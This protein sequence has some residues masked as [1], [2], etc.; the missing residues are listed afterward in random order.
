MA[1]EALP[2]LAAAQGG[3]TLAVEMHDL[4][5]SAAL[6]ARLAQRLGVTLDDRRDTALQIAA[7]MDRAQ[8]TAPRLLLL[9][10]A[11]HLGDL[12]DWLARLQASASTLKL[13][14]TSRVRLQVP[15]EQRADAAGP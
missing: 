1:T 15:D 9:D 13:L 10:N 8:D 2:L 14:V 7:A 4:D 5:D 11:E 3:P 6:A 12:S